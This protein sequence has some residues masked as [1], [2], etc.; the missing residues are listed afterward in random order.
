MKIRRKFIEAWPLRYKLTALM[1]VSTTAVSVLGMSIYVVNNIEDVR[2]RLEDESRVIARAV[3]AYSAPDLAFRDVEAANATFAALV[4]VPNVAN[5]FLFDN[6]ARVFARL[7]AGGAAPSFTRADGTRV[8]RDEKFLSVIEPVLHKTNRHGTLVLQYSLQPLRERVRTAWTTFAAMTA[9]AMALAV[10]LALWLQRFVSRPIQ[11]LAAAAQYVARET[12]FGYRVVPASRDEIGALYAVFNTML[13]RID[14]KRVELLKTYEEV[15]RLNTQLEQRVQLRTAELTAA[16]KE[17]EAFSYSASHDL[18]APLRAIHGFS[19]ALA[20]DCGATMTPACCDN[21][22]RIQAASAKMGRLIDD[23]LQLSQVTRADL[24]RVP[25][26]LSELAARTLDELRERDP[27]RRVEI[28]I[29]PTAPVQA[30]AAL[31]GIAFE[32]LLGNAWKFTRD[33]ATARIEFGRREQA[34]EA[35]YFVR[36]NGVGFDM[37]YADKLFSPFHRLH[38][39]REFE[40]TGIGLSIVQR[41][42]QR[43]GGRIWAEARPGEGATFYFTMGGAT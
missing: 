18:R 10:L 34:G 41:I 28:V 9:A 15:K 20:E 37:A 25:T 13:E 17:L 32:N 35:I 39:E 12:D 29:A 11:D 14:A 40:G 22:R 42:I 16:N 7:R 1:T 8:E 5:A 6:D 27:E 30:D 24:V 19:A 33:R 4:D 2:A 26:P 36:D 38:S 23:L 31:M 43:H 3:A 21:L